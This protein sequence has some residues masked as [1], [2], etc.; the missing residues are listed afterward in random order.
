LEQVFG[1]LLEPDAEVEGLQAED[2]WDGTDLK[3][4]VVGILFSRLVPLSK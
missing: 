3:Q 4:H 2:R 1:K